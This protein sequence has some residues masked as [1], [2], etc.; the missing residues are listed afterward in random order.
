MSQLTL[1]QGVGREGPAS[2]LFTADS[3]QPSWASWLFIASHPKHK[4][5]FAAFP[6]LARGWLSQ[7]PV[8]A[9]TEQGT[10][11][12]VRAGWGHPRTQGP[13]SKAGPHLPQVNRVQTSPPALTTPRRPCPSLTG[14]PLGTR[15]QAPVYFKSRIFRTSNCARLLCAQTMAR[16]VAAAAQ[17]PHLEFGGCCQPV[18]GLGFKGGASRGQCD[19][20]S[21]LGE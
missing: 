16:P 10:G 15:S 18:R 6:S 12:Q 9:D 14:R 2:S 13:E 4:L 11:V 5:L 7:V 17:P 8:C 3:P 19:G 1:I 21:G 20:G